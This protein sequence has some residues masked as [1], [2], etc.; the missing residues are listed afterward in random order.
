MHDKK[1]GFTLIEILVVVTII[2]ILSAI[3]FVTLNT[4]RARARDAVRIGD[5]NQISKGLDLYSSNHDG[6]FPIAN[7]GECLDGT[8][9]VNTALKDDEIIS[10]NIVDPT[11]DTP[12][13]CY[14]YTSDG[15]TYSID[16]FL[17]TDGIDTQGA[18]TFSPQ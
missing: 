11:W 4:V 16:Y 15:E 13:R 3:G 14:L 2:G 17:E 10:S 1:R 8:D 18:H 9:V 5:I 7:P 6:G 12:P